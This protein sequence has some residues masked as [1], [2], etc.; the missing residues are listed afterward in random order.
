MRV[1]KVPT[2]L[3]VKIL[4][5]F[6]PEGVLWHSSSVSMSHLLIN[7]SVITKFTCMTWNRSFWTPEEALTINHEGNP[8]LTDF[9]KLLTFI[10]LSFILFAGN[11][12]HCE[13]MAWAVDFV[14]TNKP[15]GINSS[16]KPLVCLIGD[17]VHVSLVVCPNIV[18][19]V[20]PPRSEYKT[21][22]YIASSSSSR[23]W[24]CSP[25][26]CWWSWVSL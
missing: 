19:N 5:R 16:W 7:S 26:T 3:L 10:F 2:V 12:K 24:F 20:L 21:S 18:S 8:V 9:R 15:W 4:D 23:T 13:G 6:H 25:A 22:L 17:Q 11:W 1:L 14:S